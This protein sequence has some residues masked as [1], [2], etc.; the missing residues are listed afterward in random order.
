MG[1]TYAAVMYGAIAVTLSS[2]YFRALPFDELVNIM[3]G[4]Y[5]AMA[6]LQMSLYPVAGLIADIWCGRYKTIT[7][8]LLSIWCGFF[9]LTI[10]SIVYAIKQKLVHAET[11]FLLVML[12]V[13]VVMFL[14]GVSGFQANAVQFSLDQLFDASSEGLSRFLHWFMWSDGLGELITRLIGAAASCS[15]L[16]R[17]KFFVY[18]TAVWLTAISF[19]MVLSYCKRQWFH[20]EPRTQNPYGTVYR[21][22]KFVAK[23]DKPIRRSA[24]TYCDD[25]RPTRMEY[26]KERFGG[27]FTTEM[28]EDVKTFLKILVM[29]FLIAPVFI[30]QVAAIYVFPLYGIH[31]GNT[32]VDYDTGCSAN[33]IFLQS[34]NLSYMVPVITMPLYIILIHPRIPRWMPRMFSRLCVGI[35]LIVTSVVV[36]LIIQVTANYNAI[37]QHQDRNLTCV[38]LA[39]VRTRQSALQMLNFHVPVL[40]IPNLLSGIALPLVYITILEFI[41]AQTPHTMKGLLMGVFYAFRGFF[42][43]IGCGLVYPFAQRGYWEAMVSITNCGF[44]YFLLSTLLGLIVLA[45]V[46]IATKLYCYRKREERPYGPSYVEEYYSRYYSRLTKTQ[47]AIG[48]EVEQRDHHTITSTYGTMT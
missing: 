28:V 44:Y 20:N 1:M 24:L 2:K 31:M 25:E 45:V 37:H 35:V 34:G 39:E 29:L 47:T 42:I 6:V 48:S 11:S 23:H 22:L 26:A 8:S 27:P 33:W 17:A 7:V 16:I 43:L 38:F 5:G 15:P 14:A 41:S 32:T 18:S 46:S 40:I 19:L 4:V 36:M 10:A 3:I 9:L 30:L 21:V 13:I 12:T